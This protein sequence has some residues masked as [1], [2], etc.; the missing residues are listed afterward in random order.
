MGTISALPFI[1]FFRGKVKKYMSIT[2]PQKAEIRSLREGLKS[3]LI[4]KEREREHM[5]VCVWRGGGGEK[6]EK[7]RISG[8]LHT[9]C[10]ASHGA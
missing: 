6:V 2:R 9:W 8:R 5:C 4:E 1:I 3:F 10:R 7:E